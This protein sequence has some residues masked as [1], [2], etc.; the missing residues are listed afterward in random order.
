MLN[1]HIFTRNVSAASCSQY[2][3]IRRSGLFESNTE[4]NSFMYKFC[5]R[6]NYRHIDLVSSSNDIQS[7]FIRHYDR[8]LFHF[9]H[10]Y[11]YIYTLHI[12]LYINISAIATKNPPAFLLTFVLLCLCQLCAILRVFYIYHMYYIQR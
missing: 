4:S 12:H 9:L 2:F 11:I 5:G 6:Q 7:P 1:A 3:R 8:I 10:T